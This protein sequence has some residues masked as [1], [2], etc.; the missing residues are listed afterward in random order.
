MN[1]PPNLHDEIAAPVYPVLPQLIDRWTGGAPAVTQGD[2]VWSYAELVGTAQALAAKLPAGE[3]VAVTGRPSFGLVAAMLAVLSSRNT[4]LTIDPDL[5]ARRQQLLVEQAAAR[6][7]LCVGTIPAALAQH[8]WTGQLTVAS[9]ASDADSAVVTPPQ[10]ADP[11]YIFFT[12]GTTGMPKGVRGCHK[13][14][15]HFLVWQ[16]ETFGIGP[17][18]RVAQLTNLSFDV[19]LRSVFVA[20]VSGATLCL[21]PAEVNLTAASVLPWLERAGITILHTVPSLAQTWLTERNLPALRLTFFAGEPLM[22]TLVRRWRKSFPNCQVVNFYGPT[23]TTMAK[24]YYIVPAE[25]DR[26][27][28]PVGWPLPHTQGLVMDDEIVI[29]TPFRTLGYINAP[30]EQALRFVPNPARNDPTDLLYRTG[31]RGRYRADGAL[32]ILGRLDH[33]VKIQGVRIEPDE[34]N[35]VIAGHPAVMASVVVASAGPALVAY[36]VA[37]GLTAPALRE[38]LIAQLPAAMVPRHLVFLDRLPLTANGKVD[39]Q[40]L[41]A[42]PAPPPYAA[43]RNAIENL[44]T[45]L[46]QQTLNVPQVGI[47]DNFF[48]LGGNSLRL[49]EVHG[50]LQEALHREVPIAQL[51]QFP[52]IKLLAAAL[53]QPAAPLSAQQR[54]ARQLAARAKPTA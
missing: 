14:L 23:E 28:Q 43:P 36:V 54:A 16:H 44:L 24:F 51:F 18:D 17:G 10:P 39:R 30:A 25:P 31:D 8:A 33:Q 40:A 27:V 41:P 48:D 26:G 3:V 35:A 52:T 53:T 15:S 7:V 21:P 22:D 49:T 42:P 13:G 32:E 5:P 34:V 47:D 19:V 6:W 50:Q 37:T 4:L 12:S 2:R 46:W 20:L 38:Y 1:A 11:A 45:G 29:R 9:D